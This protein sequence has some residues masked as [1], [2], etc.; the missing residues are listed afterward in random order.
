MNLISD[1]EML[2]QII[3]AFYE[4]SSI[5]SMIDDKEERVFS[6]MCLE[7]C[8]LCQGEYLATRIIANWLVDM[9]KKFN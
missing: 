9:K 2:N 4:D 7:M 6:M 8:F 5:I 1:A 3:V